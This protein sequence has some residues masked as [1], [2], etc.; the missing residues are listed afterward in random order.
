MSR[1]PRRQ[2][3][4]DRPA[5]GSICV[6]GRPW[7]SAQ[8]ENCRFILLV[9]SDDVVVMAPPELRDVVGGAVAEP[10]PNELRRGASQNSEPV[11]I[12]VLADYQTPF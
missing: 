12:F 11:K 9:E 1:A 8:F 5:V 10:N 3:C 7:Y 4:T 2:D 6:L